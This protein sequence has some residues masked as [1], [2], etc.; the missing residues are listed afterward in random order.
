MH[1]VMENTCILDVLL[2]QVNDSE[3]GTYPLT[4]PAT[5]EKEAAI[6]CRLAEQM[7]RSLST[8]V[9]AGL[10]MIEQ[11]NSRIAPSLLREVGYELTLSVRH[12]NA[13]LPVGYYVSVRH[14]YVHPE[15]R[16][17]WEACLGS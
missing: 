6:V 4:I 1:T 9:L 15:A 13:K 16:A 10:E 7:G 3:D 12:I 14:L 17:G 11:G 2:T 8:R 5:T